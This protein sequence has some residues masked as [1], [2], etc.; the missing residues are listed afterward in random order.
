MTS[1]VELS[2]AGRSAQ[3]HDPDRFLMSL[4]APAAQREA[5]FLLIAFNHELVRAL[6]MPSARGDSG[7][8]GTLIRL[9]W[10]REVVEGESRRHELAE[11]FA[12]AVS[13]GALDRDTLLSVIEA[14]EAEAEGIET[15]QRW[16]ELQLAGPGG[17]QVAFGRA[18]GETDPAMLEKLRLIGAA[19]GAGAICRH[20]QAILRIGR[21]PI[22]DELLHRS[23]T[24]RDGVR[25]VQT[26]PIDLGPLRSAGQAWL[27]EAD[28]PRLGRARIAAALPAIL[29][30]RDLARAPGPA[31]RRGIGDRMALTAAWLRGSP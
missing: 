12:A 3:A 4:F 11:P 27:A 28:R 5:F 9:Q 20:W 31:T 7:P 16:S 21:C 22:P 19:Y 29:A 23:G 2:P 6:E 13:A 17:L 15:L 25:A 1:A 30:R 24:S 18:L 14:R 10:W 8:I 26:P